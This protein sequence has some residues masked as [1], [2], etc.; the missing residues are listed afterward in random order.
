M[1]KSKY[2]ERF[3]KYTE[4]K[5]GRLNSNL[6]RIEIISMPGETDDG[7]AISKGGIIM[8]A[9]DHQRSDFMM[10]KPILGVILEVGAG[11]YDPDSKEDIPL[12]YQ[13]GN[14]VWVPAAAIGRLSIMPENGEPI[15][16][17]NMAFVNEGEVR[18]VWATF[19]D[20]ENDFKALSN[21]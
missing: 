12:D 15:P 13:V 18:K 3:Q 4:A 8:A 17:S 20:F 7:H 2:L 6:L 11:Y 5:K 19:E 1:L 21:G 14:V 16:D 9:S 10:L